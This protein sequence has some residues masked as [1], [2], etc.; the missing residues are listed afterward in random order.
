MQA[1]LLT[2][3]EESSTV[4]AVACA[5]VTLVPSVALVM[6]RRRRT[7]SAMMV[8]DCTSTTALRGYNLL[9]VG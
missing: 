5:P 2:V 8:Q 6:S 4:V 9:Q 1:A 3:M 7:E